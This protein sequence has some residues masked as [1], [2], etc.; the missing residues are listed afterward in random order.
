MT[1]NTRIIIGSNGKIKQRDFFNYYTSRVTMFYYQM[2][3]DPAAVCDVFLK[4][5]EGKV[6]DWIFEN[7]QIYKNL[8]ISKSFTYENCEIKDPGYSRY[9]TVY[10]DVQ[11]TIK[12]NWDYSDKFFTLQDN[13]FNLTMSKQKNQQD[14]I[15]YM[16]GNFVEELK[17]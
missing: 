14:W 11:G 16:F 4:C 17:R 6:P 13:Q 15:E 8:S 5:P 3:I 10:I 9:F 1:E 12:T 7:V 2:A